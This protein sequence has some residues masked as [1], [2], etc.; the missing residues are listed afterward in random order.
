MAERSEFDPSN[1]HVNKRSQY[2]LKE[3]TDKSE[4]DRRRAYLAGLVELAR[5]VE[6]WQLAYFVRLV[7]LARLAEPWQP[8][9]FVRLVELAWLAR[10]Y[11]SYQSV[12]VQY[13]WSVS[14]CKE[15]GDFYIML[16]PQLVTFNYILSPID[17]F[18]NCLS[19]NIN[20]QIYFDKLC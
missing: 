1:S 12:S 14:Y 3:M 4:H 8:A 15:I 13:K 17:D 20:L 7:E 11:S 5:L 6:P 18:E 19:K 10:K 2:D 16:C 9:Y